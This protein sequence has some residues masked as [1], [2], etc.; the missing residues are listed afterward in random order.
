MHQVS[1]SLSSAILSLVLHDY[2]LYGLF[3]EERNLF[4]AARVVREL[5]S[6]LAGPLGLA[7]RQVPMEDV[8]AICQDQIL[9]DAVERLYRFERQQQRW[10]KA[11]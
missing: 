9:V 5:R 7:K 10:L 1:A 11:A 6:R 2:Q 8:M 3:Q 4:L